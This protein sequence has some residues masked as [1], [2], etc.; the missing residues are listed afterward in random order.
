VQVGKPGVISR[1][2]ARLRR[3]REERGLS[4]TAFAGEL[5]VSRTAIQNWESGADLPALSRF[6]RISEV[7]GKPESWFFVEEE[8]AEV[9][10]AVAGAL[11]ELEMAQARLAVAQ[12][13]LRKALAPAQPDR[14][15]EPTPDELAARRAARVQ[16]AYEHLREAQAASQVDLGSEE[17]EEQSLRALADTF[18]DEDDD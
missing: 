9:T 2:P 18:A 7:T 3:A 11:H 13:Q 8:P 14:V 6:A 1:L 5:D 4:Q 17:A 12:E 16:H 10:G 15:A